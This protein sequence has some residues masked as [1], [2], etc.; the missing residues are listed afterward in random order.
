LGVNEDLVWEQGD[1]YQN[2]K[3]CFW[4]YAEKL[5]N[6]RYVANI[7]PYL[8]DGWH[9]QAGALRITH[10]QAEAI[11]PR[12]LFLEGSHLPFVK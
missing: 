5:G 4:T 8:V 3:A 1:H 6:A 11:T 12:R 10:A 7:G 9:Q 2:P